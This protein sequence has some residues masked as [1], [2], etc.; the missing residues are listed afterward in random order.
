MGYIFDIPAICYVLSYCIYG[1]FEQDSPLT[2]SLGNVAL[3][4]RTIE[5]ELKMPQTKWRQSMFF[6]KPLTFQLPLQAMN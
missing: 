1:F 4:R 3:F 6:T 2:Q 5:V